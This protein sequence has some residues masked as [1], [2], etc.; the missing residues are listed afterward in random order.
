ASN[1]Y[2]TDIMFVFGNVMAG[3]RQVETAQ[4]YCTT[5]SSLTN[6]FQF[7]NNCDVGGIHNGQW[8][9]SNDRWVTSVISNVTPPKLPQT[10]Y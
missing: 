1:E 2:I 7:V 4:I 9:M 6:G 10:G 8:I 5:H 3:F